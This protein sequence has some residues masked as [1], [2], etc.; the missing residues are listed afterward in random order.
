MAHPVWQHHM[1]R[2]TTTR[3][4]LCANKRESSA[5]PSRVLSCLYVSAIA[6]TP[7]TYRYTRRSHRCQSL[8]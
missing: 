2:E 8:L 4:I 7:S 3:G 1:L 5:Q 6:V